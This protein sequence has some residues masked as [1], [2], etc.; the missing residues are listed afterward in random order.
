MAWS[1]DPVA[2]HLPFD[3]IFAARGEPALGPDDPMDVDGDGTITV[4]DG[5]ACVLECTFANCAQTGCG[6]LGI[7]PM[8]LIGGALA[9]RRHRADRRAR[10]DHNENADPRGNHHE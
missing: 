7:E 10:T 2:S 1:L 5:R 8:L 6:L 3:L 9:L 4:L